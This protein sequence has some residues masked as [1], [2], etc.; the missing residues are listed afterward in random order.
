MRGEERVVA[1]RGGGLMVMGNSG[2]DARLGKQSRGH[3][4]LV[5]VCVDAVHGC[6]RRGEGK[7]KCQWWERG[8]WSRKRR[9]MR[10]LWVFKGGPKRMVNGVVARAFF[11][12]N[13]G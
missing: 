1:R 4:R 13:W 10:G 5:L 6:D 2:W 7:E 9:E 12:R 3:E 11:G 8:R